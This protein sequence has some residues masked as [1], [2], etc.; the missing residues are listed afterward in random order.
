[1]V[2]IQYEQDIQF[3]LSTLGAATALKAATKVD[4]SRLNGFRIAKVNVA[5]TLRNKTASEGPILWGLQCNMSAADIK[6][7]IESDPQS[8]TADN[9]RGDGTWL[10]IL[11]LIG[12][13][14]T[15]APLTGGVGPGATAV[16]L[17]AHMMEVKVNW[18]V[19]EG[20]DFSVFAFNMGSGALTTGTIIDAVLEIFGVWLRD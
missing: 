15:D 14:T 20:Q 13:P 7:A 1:M 19:I 16:S 3:A 4:A 11:G 10:K 5:A 12:F 6:A 18:S 8:S 9:D 2:E 17:V